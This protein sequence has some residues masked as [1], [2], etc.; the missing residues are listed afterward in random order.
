MSNLLRTRRFLPLFLTQFF[1]A[2]NDNLLKNA[3]VILITYRIATQTGENPQIL[4]TLAALLF[5]LP[6]FLFSATSG[7]IA[8][9]YD[10][11]KL[12][13]IIKL[14]E[15]GI[16]VAAT[17]GF[18]AQS[19][20]FL[21]A[22]LFAMGTHSTFFSPLKFALLPQH[23]HDDELLLGNGYIE[24]G[25]FLAILFGTILGGILVL[26]PGGDLLVSAALMAVALLGYASSRA[27]PPAPAPDPALRIN[28][29]IWRETWH[30]V[31]FSRAD[32]KLFLCILG[33][34]W[35][36]L[37][38]ATLL[39]QFPPYVKEVLHAEA[40]VVTLF[41]T[42]FS[43]G[44][45]IGSLLCNKLLRGEIKST[46][47][48]YAALGIGLFSADL[49]LASLHDFSIAADLMPIGQFLAGAAGIRIL[50]DLLM[51]AVSA[52]IYIVPLYAIMQHKSPP[53]HRARIIAANNIVNALFMVAAAVLTLLLLTLNFTIPEVFLV[54]AAANLA[55]AAAIRRL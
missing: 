37:V 45:G 12:V 2:F 52:G 8:D 19:V 21:M 43:V 34:S 35:F 13:R 1:G 4:V 47:A 26:Q 44:V 27:I 3:L 22:V 10:R 32:R 20:W 42:V 51:I 6:Y 39:S 33:I 55:V 25:S 36:W 17:I 53:A 18:Y 14:V 40:S 50:F 7:Q 29:N 31:A 41:L 24:A 49:Y 23:L 30:I 11:A 48:P 15:I 46:F 16:M 54:M 38:G 5:I 9:K 28:A